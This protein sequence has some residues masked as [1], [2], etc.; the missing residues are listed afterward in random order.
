MGFEM[1]VIWSKV[2]TDENFVY[3][4]NEKDL[5]LADGLMGWANCM[6]GNKPPKEFGTGMVKIG[7]LLGISC[8]PETLMA[9]SQEQ[10]NE[11]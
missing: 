1:E 11:N 5:A 3:R 4:D 8:Q 9:Y 2:F 6:A 10:T 7:K